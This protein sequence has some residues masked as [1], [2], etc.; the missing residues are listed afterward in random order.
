MGKQKKLLLVLILILMLLLMQRQLLLLLLMILARVLLPGT[1]CPVQQ[2]QEEEVEVLAYLG[3]VHASLLGLQ[4]VVL[5]IKP[6]FPFLS[7]CSHSFQTVSHR[8]AFANPLL[9]RK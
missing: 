1:R 9:G 4:T 2:E 8:G 7:T 6:E 5:F 3:L